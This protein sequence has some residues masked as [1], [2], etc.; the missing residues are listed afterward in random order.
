MRMVLSF[1]MILV[2]ITS[3]V[4]A[5]NIVQVQPYKIVLNSIK[6]TA[7]TIQVSVP[8]SVVKV[9]DLEASISIGGGEGISSVGFYY[10]AIDDVLHIYFDKD[11]VIEYIMDNGIEGEVEA[12]LNG[13]FNNGDEVVDIN[14]SDIVEVHNP[15]QK[16][17][18]SLLVSLLLL[19]S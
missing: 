12:Y 3:T 2:L 8:I 16:K 5:D 18:D 13:S 10:C 14:G 6:G 19:L 9:E 1:S 4:F 15:T 7:D 11:E 17:L